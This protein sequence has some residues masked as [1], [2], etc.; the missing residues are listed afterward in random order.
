MH[1]VKLF[2]ASTIGRVDEARRVHEDFK[3]QHLDINITLTFTREHLA[4]LHPDYLSHFL[5]G[6]RKAGVPE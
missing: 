1:Y 5:E 2:N 3:R 4:Q 6:L